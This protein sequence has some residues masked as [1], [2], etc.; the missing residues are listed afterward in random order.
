[1]PLLPFQHQLITVAVAD[2]RSADTTIKQRATFLALQAVQGPL[3]QEVMVNI[4]VR[5]DLYA[6][7]AGQY[8]ELLSGRGLNSYEITLI[9]DNNTAVDPRTGEVKHIR[10]TESPTQW[11][12]LL[13]ADEAPLMLQGD[14]FELLLNNQPVAIGPMIEQFIEQADQP[15][16]S[17][18]A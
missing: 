14:W 12:A 8:G 15:P 17:K 9:A 7:A 18:F 5:V 1:M 13:D 11:L 4:R 10:S 3:T 6:D 16:F 2:R